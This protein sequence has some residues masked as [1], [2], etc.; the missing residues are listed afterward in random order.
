L[1][2]AAVELYKATNDQRYLEIAGLTFQFMFQNETETGNGMTVL[3]DNGQSCSSDCDSF[4]GIGIRYIYSLWQTQD[5]L[6]KSENGKQ[7][8]K[9]YSHKNEKQQKQNLNDQMKQLLLDCGNAVWQNR[10]SFFFSVDWLYKPNSPYFQATQASA[11]MSLSI[12][13]SITN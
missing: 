4:K 9:N 6:M 5:N 7:F 8:K 13:S 3:T 12:L 1:I 11:L 2:G 10:N